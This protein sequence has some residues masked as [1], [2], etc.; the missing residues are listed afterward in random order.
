[1]VSE[2]QFQQLFGVLSR[3]AKSLETLAAAVDE[4]ENELNVYVHGELNGEEEEDEEEEEEYEEEL[5]EE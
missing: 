5:E 2:E 1:M 4:D 3:I